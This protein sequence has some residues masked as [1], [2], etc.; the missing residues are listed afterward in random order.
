MCCENIQ[1]GVPFEIKDNH[2]YKTIM[3]HWLERHKGDRKTYAFSH[4][5]TSDIH[6]VSNIYT[7]DDI[8]AEVFRDDEGNAHTDLG[9]ALYRKGKQSSEK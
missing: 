4:E 6:T 9:Y 5:P 1:V 8:S 3:D 7:I 2:T